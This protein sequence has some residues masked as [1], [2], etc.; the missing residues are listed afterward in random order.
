MK[1]YALFC[2]L[3][4]VSVWVNAKSFSCPTLSSEE[5]Q[6]ID[7]SGVTLSVEEEDVPPSE[8][9]NKTKK[10]KSISCKYEKK[11]TDSKITVLSILVISGLDIDDEKKML[12]ELTEGATSDLDSKEQKE[13]IFRLPI[14]NGV[15]LGFLI[16]NDFQMSM[17]TQI[18]FGKSVMVVTPE[19]AIN[20]K[21]LP[22]LKPLI[23]LN[24]I[25]KNVAD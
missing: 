16:F 2:L 9:F 22:P 23:Y 20:G 1:R 18:H 7:L 19:F 24:R 11:S 6:G 15:C 8:K 10:L 12:K 4:G 5:L 13:S 21:P 17:C 25:S 14:E 3:L